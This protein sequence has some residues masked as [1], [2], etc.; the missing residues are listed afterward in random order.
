[1]DGPRRVSF[2]RYHP[3]VTS[4]PLRVQDVTV[5]GHPALVVD[6]GGPRAVITTDVGPTY[7]PGRGSWS[8]TIPRMV[9][10]T[11]KSFFVDFCALKAVSAF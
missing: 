10:V 2:V 3:H 6:R 8:Y 11:V 7:S 4:H 1:M 9:E 5:D